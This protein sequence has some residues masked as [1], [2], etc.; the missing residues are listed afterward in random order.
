MDEA[1]VPIPTS[2]WER[3]LADRRRLAALA[4]AALVLLGLV[5]FGVARALT[6]GEGADRGG[7][8]LELPPADPPSVEETVAPG[9]EETSSAGPGGTGG[10]VADPD[11]D[12]ATPGAAPSVARRAPLVA[13]RLGGEVFVAR[14]DGS[15]PVRVA[16]SAEGVFALSPDG[17]TL[18]LVE[19]GELSFV[20]VD[21]SGRT[22][23]GPAAATAIAWWPDSSAVAVVRPSTG[24]PDVTEVWRVPLRGG[25]PARVLDAGAPSIGPDGTL[26]APAPASADAGGAPRGSVWVVPRGGTASAVPVSG[27]PTECAPG[28]GSVVFALQGVAPGAAT[29]A[30]EPG[31]WAMRPDGASQRRIVGPPASPIPFGYGRLSLSPDGRTLLFAEV[32]DDGYSRAFTVPVAGGTPRPLTVRRDTYPLGW[33]SDGA[34]VFF[35]EGNAFQGEPTSLM[36]AAPDGTGRRVVVEGAGL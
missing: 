16:A 26:A 24:A 18:A 15:Q 28:A 5:G 21:G 2:W 9:A 30:I 34:R 20:A 29:P 12:G 17:R 8:D 22:P 7:A 35:V 31:V 3:M 11:D 25:S 19:G 1:P 33:S 4:V 10:A 23:A 13:Y 6:S 27:H 32:G 14:E 36:S